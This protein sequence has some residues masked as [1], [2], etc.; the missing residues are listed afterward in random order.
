MSANERQVGG[1]HYKTG[2]EEH[3]D[4]VHRLQLDYFQAQI[5][6]YVERCWQKNG[7][8]DLQKAKHFL[9]KY[10]ELNAHRVSVRPPPPLSPHPHVQAFGSERAPDGWIGYTFEG[11]TSGQDGFRCTHCRE[12]F[13]VPV[14]ANPNAFHIC[15][16]SAHD[17]A[18]RWQGAPAAATG[19]QAPAPAAT[20]I[21][22][23]PAVPGGNG[24]D[25]A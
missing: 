13:Y 19:E 8:E 12:H 24:V 15:T 20:A 1:S 2:G 11:S 23:A 17:G 3:W 5:T 9:D 18:P 21:A 6:K 4:R 7:V 22:G 10:I 25:T 16:A 14:H